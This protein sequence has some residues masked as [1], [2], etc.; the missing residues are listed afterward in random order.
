[1]APISF[2][3]L[4]LAASLLLFS[5]LLCSCAS[6][7]RSGVHRRVASRQQV[8]PIGVI[9]ENNPNE[10]PHLRRQA[11]SFRDAPPYGIMMA[12]VISFHMRIA[13]IPGASP[14]Q[15]RAFQNIASIYPEPYRQ[16]LDGGATTV[17]T[18]FVIEVRSHDGRARRVHVTG[19]GSAPR[20]FGN[21]ILNS[22]NDAGRKIVSEIRNASFESEP[23]WV[24]GETPVSTDDADDIST[25]GVAQFTERNYPS[26]LLYFDRAVQADPSHQA[27]W[28]YRGATLVK[29]GRANEGRQ[30]LEKAVAIDPASAEAEQARKWL[31][32]INSL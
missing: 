9:I 23:V 17:E 8:S 28:S 5:G 22:L 7:S 32:R 29:L 21:P 6:T 13:R 4:T 26:A 30:S 16:Y 2:R 20:G 15:S 18:P 1:M 14:R 27:A 3:R 24:G 10:H 11:D 25:Q 31:N 12:N 19:I